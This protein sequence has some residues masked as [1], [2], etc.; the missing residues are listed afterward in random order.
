[1]S[2]V[3]LEIDLAL[4]DEAVAI[5]DLPDIGEQ[6]DAAAV[7]AAAQAVAEAQR[8]QRVALL[9]SR[10]LG[11]TQHLLSD[12]GP[13]SPALLG[14]YRIAMLTGA[15]LRSV[16]ADTDPSRGPLSATSERKTCDSLRAVLVGLLEEAAADGAPPGGAAAVL[17]HSLRAV[18]VLEA[19]VEP[20]A[21]AGGAKRRRTDDD[22]TAADVERRRVEQELARVRRQRAAAEEEEARLEARLRQLPQPQ[23]EEPRGRARDEAVRA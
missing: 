11:L 6:P 19:L 2:G 21:A 17:Q 12:S 5:S 8:Q 9:E 22:S 1:M 20:V 7:Q 13:L 18:G 15:E 3:Q 4:P 14:A 23:L 16:S 10:G